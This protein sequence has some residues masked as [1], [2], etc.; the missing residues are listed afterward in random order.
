MPCLRPS[1]ARVQVQ[2]ATELGHLTRHGHEP[3]V[4]GALLPA[5]PPLPGTLRTRRDRSPPPASRPAARPA[6]CMPCLRP[7]R[8]FAYAFNQP[9]TWDTSRV[10]TTHAMLWVH[11]Y[12][13]SAPLICSCPLSSAR[14]VHTAIASASSRLPARSAPRTVCPACDPR[15]EARAFNQPLSWNLPRVTDMQIMFYVRCAPRVPSPTQ[16]AVAPSPL[17]AACTPIAP[18]HPR[19]AWLARRPSYPACSLYDSA[20]QPHA[21]RRQQAAHPLRVGGHPRL[22]L[23]WLS[24]GLGAGKLQLKRHRR[25]ERGAKK[26][27]HT[28]CE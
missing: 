19:V 1:A 13:R 10:T 14:C 7:S 18:V 25:Q 8:Q 9:P 26:R 3:H 11:C 23:R 27:V 4:S 15:Q 22:R 17:P 28:G 21:V 12:P 5:A 6:P 20:E 24:L 16:P 2:P